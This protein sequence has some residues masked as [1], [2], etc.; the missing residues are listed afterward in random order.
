MSTASRTQGSVLPSALKRR[1]TRSAMGPVG[2]WSPGIH[3]GYTRS[4]VCAN[5]EVTG[6][7]SCA[8]RIFLEMVVA[9]TSRTMV[10]AVS[11]AWAAVA[12]DT[13]PSHNRP[14][15]GA[16]QRRRFNK[17]KGNSLLLLRRRR[18][19]AAA[20]EPQVQNRMQSVRVTP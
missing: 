8:E 17:R 5:G 14:V 12:E 11:W 13:S 16:K 4:M 20:L 6:N 15:Y 3:L 19:P 10:D 2:A 1:F 18:M 9:S 7:D